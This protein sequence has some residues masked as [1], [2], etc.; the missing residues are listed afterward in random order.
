MVGTAWEPKSEEFKELVTVIAPYGPD[1]WASCTS[2][3]TVDLWNNDGTYQGSLTESI[4]KVSGTYY[5]RSTNIIDRINCFA[6]DISV[7]DNKICYAGYINRLIMGKASHV[8]IEAN[9]AMNEARKVMNE[10][11]EFIIKTSQVKSADSQVM[12]EASQAVR[13]ASQA[14]R[15][16]S[17]VI[18][19]ASQAIRE[20]PGAQRLA[21]C[22]L[23]K[24][25][26]G[27]Y[28]LSTQKVMAIV[29]S[30]L[31]IFKFGNKT[32]SEDLL[33]SKEYFLKGREELRAIFD[34][35]SLRDN[36][37]ICAI[38]A[39]DGTI[40]VLDLPT[41]TVLWTCE[42]HEDHVRKVVNI[43]SDVFASCSDDET[44][45]IWDVRCRKSVATVPGHASCIISPYE[46]LLVSAS[47]PKKYF[48]E[49]QLNYLDIR[50]L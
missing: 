1:C 2:D 30:S 28:P 7:E 48:K 41:K 43:S 50:K 11:E 8:I 49:V 3:G 16:A 25:V 13:E 19:E 24:Y 17:Q 31:R 14:V 20:A 15:E 34:V 10:A 5:K 47:Y 12:R 40:T 39:F 9:Q 32:W 23:K 35:C 21:E 37:N 38:P 36:F 46:N 44:S 18:K 6:A 45:K 29:D 22:K 4:V 27:I 33:V 26:S 42:E